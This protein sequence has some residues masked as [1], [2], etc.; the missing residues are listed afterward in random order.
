LAC[1]TSRSSGGADWVS[2]DRFDVT[3][4]LNGNPPTGVFR[5]QMRPML[6]R[7]LYD[8]F[9]L[10]THLV[11][12][13][14]PVYALVFARENA[15]L[16]PEL[17][18]ADPECADAA[19]RGASAPPPPNA[20]PTCGGGFDRRG[21][22][23]ARAVPFA[24][25]V[26]GLSGWVDRIVVDETKL[27]GPYDWHVKWDPNATLQPSLGAAGDTPIDQQDVSLFTAIREQLGLELKPKRHLIDVVVIDSV[28]MPSSD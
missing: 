5:E 28:Q 4:K 12:R 18:R 24:R 10:R 23:L 3:G 6:S 11:Q 9:A 2:S 14:S 1:A 25:L 22:M 17:K 20:Q 26:T 15:R 8:R 27:S 19:A 16:G 21:E 13:E 7:L